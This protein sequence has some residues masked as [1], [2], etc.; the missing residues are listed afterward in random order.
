M[1]NMKITTFDPLI[2]SAEAEA[3][4]KLFEE[5]GFEKNHVKGSELEGTA[6]DSV[7]MKNEKGFLVDL[8][9]VQVPKDMMVIRM[10]VDDLD[11]AKAILEKHGFVNA[12]AGQRRESE[13]HYSE[14]MA[15]P[16]GFAINL[17]KH[18]KK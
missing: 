10:N 16:S 15:L 12:N 2:V 18:V 9:N 6:F 8:A 4:I 5:L 7:Q 17:V 3:A 14:F 1:N 11:E 13:N